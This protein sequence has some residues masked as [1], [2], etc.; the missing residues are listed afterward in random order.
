MSKP[1]FWG[2]TAHSGVYDRMEEHSTTSSPLNR[3]VKLGV[4]AES[5]IGDEGTVRKGSKFD[6]DYYIHL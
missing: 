4:N 6:L 2:G 5:I 3:P 1:G